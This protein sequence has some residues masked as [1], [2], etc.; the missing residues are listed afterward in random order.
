MTHICKLILYLEE[1][2]TS[3]CSM[4]LH[5]RPLVTPLSISASL[6]FNDMQGL[7]PIFSKLRNWVRLSKA[8]KPIY[9]SNAPL[10]N[11]RPEI[12]LQLLSILDL[13][14]L[15]HLVHASPIFHQQYLSDLG[16]LLC[17]CL[18]TTLRS[19]TPDACSVYWSCTADFSARRTREKV[20]WFLEFYDDQ[21]SSSTQYSIFTERSTE[22]EAMGIVAFYSSIIKPLVRLYT[23][24]ALTNLADE[25]KEIQNHKK[26]SS[27][28]DTRLLRGLFRFQLYCKLFAKGH[29]IN[30]LQPWSEFRD[31]E[32]LKD[33]ICIFE[34]WEIE[35]IACIY[36]FSKEKYNKIFDEIRWDVHKEN[37]KFEDQQR[38]PT[39]DGAFDL[40]SSC[41]FHI[42]IP[43]SLVYH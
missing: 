9:A 32:T 15:E 31:V 33:F 22:D 37:P 34:P 36:T 38:P 30:Y 6:S 4:R 43:F 10:E 27:T 25:S 20:T 41:K 14:E 12:R 23:N 5:G 21:R 3:D 26:L 11:L 2:E 24:W 17:K 19:I 8:L 39:P 13:E 42:S 7:R 16:P 29:H 35:E 18:E 1:R 40:D 28:E